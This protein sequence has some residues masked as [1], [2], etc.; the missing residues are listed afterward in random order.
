MRVLVH[1]ADLHAC[2]HYR[3]IWPARAVVALGHD[4]TI[5][6]DMTYRAIWQPAVTGDRIIG[7]AQDVDVDVIVFQRPLHRNRVE[8]IKV[9]QALGVAV[10]VEVDDDFH[11]IHPKN[12]AWKTTNPLTDRDCNR[13]WLAKACDLAD[14]VTVSTPALAA[15]YGHHGR[16][17]VLDNYIPAA[18][19]DLPRAVHDRVRVG[20]AGSTATH[21][22]DLE[23]TE[24]GVAHAI[25][26]TGAQLTVI[27]TGVGVAEAL[28]WD[29]DVA[30]CGWVDLD[31]YPAALAGLDVGIV[32]L[33]LS[34]FNEAKSHLKG[35]EMAAV[36]VPFVASPTGPYRR[37]ADEGIGWLA[38]T[39]ADWHWQVAELARDRHTRQLL[40]ERYRAEVAA[41]WT[42]ERHAP[43]W[44]AAWERAFAHRRQRATVTDG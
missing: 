23:V 30:A 44:W 20:W 16:V 3:M 5:R 43:K 24:G 36:G 21:P 7:L 22:G 40:G 1:P 32:P 11:A 34:T 4:V 25:R 12:P 9:L 39:Y 2:G 13:D 29:G 14:L 19:L 35:L 37:L 6:H 28:R 42:I 8:L 38:E 33:Q 26:D 10:V 27:G 41:R 17:V 31:A 18:Y 15:R